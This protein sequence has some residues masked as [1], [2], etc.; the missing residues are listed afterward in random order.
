MCS[1][2]NLALRVISSDNIFIYLKIYFINE[3]LLQKTYRPI[4]VQNL[5]LFSL[6]WHVFV[7]FKLIFHR[8]IGVFSDVCSVL[9]VTRS[10]TINPYINN[11]GICLC[12]FFFLRNCATIAMFSL[13]TRRSYESFLNI[14]NVTWKQN[15]FF[16]S[17]YSICRHTPRMCMNRRIK[18]PA[19]FHRPL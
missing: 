11:I 7:R 15:R 6:V 5:R 8:T 16:G 13:K 9:D 3:H 2:F 18:N 4:K 10:A 12:F 17:E 1:L 14:I 19:R